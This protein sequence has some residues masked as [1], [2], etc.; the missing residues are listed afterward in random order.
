VSAGSPTS[1]VPQVLSGQIVAFA[2][3][4]TL[5]G[6]KEARELVE[7]LGGTT[8]D[9]VT[10]KTT[11]LV[12]GEELA[13]QAEPDAAAREKSP[14]IRRAEELNANQAGVIEIISEDAF[15]RL[16][17]VPAP[18]DLR[19]HYHGTRE[20]LARYRALREDHLR[21]LV[22]CGAIKPAQRGNT[23][24]FFAFQDLGLIKQAHDELA[25]GSTFRSIV[26]SLLAEQEGQLSFDFRLDAEPAR[27]ISLEGRPAKTPTVPASTMV[28]PSIRRRAEMAEEYFKT[29][30][31]L[32]N[33]DEQALAEAAAAYR[34]ALELD[35]YLVAA[36]INLANIHYGRD[37][38]IE[39]QALYEQAIGLDSEY[40]EAHFNLGNI[41]HDLGRF[42]EAQRCYSEALRLN[43]TY[44]DAHFYLA[45]TFEKMGLSQE[46]RRHWTAYRQLA[47]KGEWVELAKEF[48][49]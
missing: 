2:G 44:A 39:A 23:E 18:A 12:V 28:A 24:I 21:Y 31:A 1:A 37:E 16:T 45:V 13:S 34:K 48:S 5:L 6:R 20:L 15:C 11:M 7:R 19:Q 8:A 47:P 27:I 41:H 36:I 22:K 43:P 10:A 25:R 14:K 26:K 49:D 42:P 35:P 3:K 32:D 38:L 46:A 4:L 40:F 33:G 9:D 17:G 30:A 29:A